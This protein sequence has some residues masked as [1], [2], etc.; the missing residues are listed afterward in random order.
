MECIESYFIII[1]FKIEGRNTLQSADS[2]L[3]VVGIYFTI[4]CFKMEYRNIYLTIFWFKKRKKVGIYCTISCSKMEGGYIL[5]FPGNKTIRENFAFCENIFVNNFFA[6]IF[7]EFA[8]YIFKIKFFWWIFA[9]FLHFFKFCIFSHFLFRQNFT[10]FAKQIEA[11]FCE[12]YV[13][14]KNG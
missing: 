7:S 8:T 6:K 1:W 12:K 3:K 9:N 14:V 2:R 11:N 10:F 13:S 4:S 5:G